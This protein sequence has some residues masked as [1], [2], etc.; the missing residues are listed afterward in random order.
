M[1]AK[2]KQWLVS[3]LW[4]EWIV[5]T[6]GSMDSVD[7]AQQTAMSLRAGNQASYMQSHQLVFSIIISH[8]ICRL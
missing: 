1:I 7:I 5:S 2:K 3:S 6:C 8:G 4:C